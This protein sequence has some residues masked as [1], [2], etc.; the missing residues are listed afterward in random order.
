MG[1]NLTWG[2]P[3][4]W[5]AIVL[6]TAPLLISASARVALPSFLEPGLRLIAATPGASL[7]GQPHTG[8]LHRGPSSCLLSMGPRAGKGSPLQASA[9]CPGAPIALGRNWPPQ[10]SDP[11]PADLSSSDR[12]QMVGRAGAGHPPLLLDP[13]QLWGIAADRIPGSWQARLGTLPAR[14][15]VAV[16]WAKREAAYCC[17]TRV[18]YPSSKVF[19][20]CLTVWQ[21]Q[22]PGVHLRCRLFWGHMSLK[23]FN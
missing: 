12:G 14:E 6:S 8:R 15:E 4:L 21:A 17:K 7:S 22:D 18:T 9:A 5:E 23:Q 2:L 13:G 10:R 16:L 19:I 1:Q 3:A 20:T 11:L